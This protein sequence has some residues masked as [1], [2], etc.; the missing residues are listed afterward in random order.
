MDSYFVD[1]NGV[2]WIKD[3]FI[4]A[5]SFPIPNPLLA[6]AFITRFINIESDSKFVWE[7]TNYSL[8]TGL[9]DY[10]EFDQLLSPNIQLQFLDS[11]S[12]TN[13]QL[14]DV[15]ASNSC[16]TGGLPF[17]LSQPKT[18]GENTTL[19]INATVTP[20]ILPYG[21]LPPNALPVFSLSL[22]GY[23]LFRG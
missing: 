11:R 8:L 14:P 22:I 5:A 15:I 4:Y 13:L 9:I 1:A 18:L 2:T 6:P 21:Q 3:H 16:G 20:R 19:Q 12:G 17:D 7:S 23:K 10:D